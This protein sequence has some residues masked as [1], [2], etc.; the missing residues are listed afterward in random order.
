MLATKNRGAKGGA[1]ALAAAAW[2]CGCTPA[3]PGSLLH[4]AKLIEQKK[5]AEAVTQL[6]RATTL[7]PTNAA[8]WNYLGLACQYAGQPAEAEKAYS[9][10]LTLDRD[11]TEAHYNLGCLMLDRGNFDGAK[12]HLTAFTMRRGGSAE[13]LTRLGAAQLKSHELA[14]AEKNLNDALK[15]NPRNLEALNLAG[16]V[17]VERGRPAEALR[18]FDGALSQQPNYAPAVLNLA[19]LAQVHSKDKQAALKRY[20]QYASLSPPPEKLEQVRAAVAQLES[21][22]NPPIHAPPVVTAPT[23]APVTNAA[24]VPVRTQSPPA[25]T[26]VA[27]NLPAPPPP[28][29]TNLV[30]EAPKPNATPV[31]TNPIADS[32]KPAPAVA[33]ASVLPP[34]RTQAIE[35]VEVA[36]QPVY[37][38]GQNVALDLARPNTAAAADPRPMVDSSATTQGTQQKRTFLQKINPLNLLHSPA[39]TTTHPA[40]LPQ[41][42]SSGAKRDLAAADPPEASSE[43]AQPASTAM[44]RYAYKSPPA[45][46]QGNR[47][48]AERLSAQGF[49]SQQSGR[50]ADAIQSYRAAV[51]QDPSFFRANYNLA[52]VLAESG[53]LEPALYAYEKALAA[54]PESV[55]A[56]LNFALTLKQGRYYVDSATEFEKVVA[57]SP[58][59]TKAHLA[60]GN[61]YAQ[62]LRQPVR[63]R[64]HYL[65]VLELEP[66]HPEASKIHYWLVSNPP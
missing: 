45:P 56:R 6:K 64:Q 35:T 37:K 49:Q 16:L 17:R 29:R 32:S 44:A 2:L 30:T 7:M 40:P 41:D 13:A 11:L 50:V 53:S 21:E 12:S 28:A 24:R 1:A 58:S 18:Y 23:P 51:Q 48:A 42:D 26:L 43:V 57:E 61:L 52:L 19:V 5:Y 8:A 10:A 47:D 62:Q 59:E 3:G 46:A 4:G 31:R 9:R 63:A 65:K 20:R 55:E 25:A 22:I 39:K 66:G 36:S 15:I 60:L 34:A 27:T 38:P 14:A 33:L 54:N